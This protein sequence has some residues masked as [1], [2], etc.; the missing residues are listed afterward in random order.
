MAPVSEPPDDGDV[1]SGPVR[2]DPA[3]QPVGWNVY[4]GS[5]GDWQFREF[6]PNEPVLS[7]AAE[8]LAGQVEAFTSE[9]EP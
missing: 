7:A 6:I 8:Q 9:P 2:L 1:Y 4:D 5:G 3:G